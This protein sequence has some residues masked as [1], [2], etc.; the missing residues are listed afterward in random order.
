MWCF[1]VFSVPLIWI[2]SSKVS[3]EVRMDLFHMNYN[4]IISYTIMGNL[5]RGCYYIGPTV[6]ASSSILPS[7]P[8]GHLWHSLEK[9]MLF[10]WG[11]ACVCVQKIFPLILEGNQCNYVQNTSFRRFNSIENWRV[12]R[13]PAISIQHKL[14][15]S[16]LLHALQRFRMGLFKKSLFVVLNQDSS[17]L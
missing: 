10:W 2:F 4:I 15:I 7:L 13:L 6:T 1:V 14:S 16:C 5:Q 12:I 3:E 17:L 9:V 11:R 8:R